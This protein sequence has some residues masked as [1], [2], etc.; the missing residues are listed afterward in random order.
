[1]NNNYLARQ[2]KAFQKMTETT[3]F[4]NCYVIS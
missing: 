3:F 1:L 4:I 2:G